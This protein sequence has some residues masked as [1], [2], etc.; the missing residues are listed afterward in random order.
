MT[1]GELKRQQKHLE[2]YNSILKLLIDNGLDARFANSIEK[3]DIKLLQW[4]S[5]MSNSP[6]NFVDITKLK[7]LGNSILRT[8]LYA[9]VYGDSH[10]S[11]GLVE[12]MKCCDIYD[13]LYIISA[14]SIENSSIVFEVKNALKF[15]QNLLTSKPEYRLKYF[16]LS[17]FYFWN[18]KKSKAMYYEIDMGTQTWLFGN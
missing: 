5:L 3:N 17:G 12:F 11:N 1:K 13:T 4:R 7:L 6:K 2:Y 14:S 16:E 15:F 10:Y 8:S 9:G 18:E